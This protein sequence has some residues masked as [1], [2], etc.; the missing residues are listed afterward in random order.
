MY[1][2]LARSFLDLVTGS[3]CLAC[4]TGGPLVC[5]E[6]LRGLP[7]TATPAWPTP[8]PP[9]LVTPWATGSYDGLLRDLVIGHKE[10]GLLALRNPLGLLLAL[11]AAA[12]VHGPCP[13]VLVPVPSR[14]SSVRARGHD[15]TYSMVRSAARHL[16]AVGVDAVPHRLLAVRA[17]LQDQAGLSA[18]ERSANLSGSL[19]CPSAAVAAL[20]RRRPR[21][22]VLICDDVLTTGATAREAQRAMEAAGLRPQAVITVAATARRHPA[23]AAQAAVADSHGVFR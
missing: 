20:H 22:Q 8:C 10:H 21:A 14:P 17:A 4:G 1:D 3:T 2:A 9:G 7:S 15:P 6:C 23:G 18:E 13:V 11:S 5:E 19:W 12:A 16:A